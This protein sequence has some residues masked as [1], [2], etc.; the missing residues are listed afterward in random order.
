MV[1]KARLDGHE[2][3]LEA[4][5]RHFDRGDVRVTRDDRGY[6][7]TAPAFDLVSA[8][9]GELMNTAQATVRAANGVVRALVTEFRPVRVTGHFDGQSADGRGINHQVVVPDGIDARSMVGTPTV[10]V[11]GV[12]AQ[13]PP[14]PAPDYL[15]LAQTNPDLQDALALLGKGV[16]GLDWFDLW[17]V[18]EIVRDNVGGFNAVVA[19][20]WVLQADLAAFKPSSNDPALSGDAARHARHTG[21]PPAKVL[22]VEQGRELIRQLVAAWLKTL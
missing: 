13:P 5:A 15:Q 22:S 21:P 6:Y 12:V 20:N 18:W 14:S 7:L 8:D 17:K 16:D 19:Q 9:A 4:L 11:G 2:F 3:D 1:V 10:S